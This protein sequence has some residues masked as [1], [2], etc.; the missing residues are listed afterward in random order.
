MKINNSARHSIVILLSW[1][2]GVSMGRSIQLGRFYRLQTQGGML[3]PYGYHPF[4]PSPPQPI[5]EEPAQSVLIA[6]A[7]GHTRNKELIILSKG[8]SL[9]GQFATS[10]Q[11]LAQLLL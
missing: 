5:L 1:V 6:L 11:G 9:R 4:T 10:A 2:L 8:D 3:R 7:Q